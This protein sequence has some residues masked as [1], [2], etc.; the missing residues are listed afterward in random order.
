[1][2]EKKTDKK[3]I[4]SQ[5]AK[6]LLVFGIL[7]IITSFIMT[8]SEG[9]S[10]KYKLDPE[11]GIIGPITTSKKNT[12]Y[13]I[14]VEQNLAQDSQWSFVSGEL[15]DENKNYLFGFGEEFWKESGYDSEGYWS[16]KVTN[17]DMDITIP[18]KG[19]YYLK[20]NSEIAQGV[21]VPILINLK[22]K[23][24]TGSAFVLM[25]IITL[26]IGVVINQIAKNT[27]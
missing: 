9:K 10:Q 20:F 24:G 27:K 1:M 5:S 7:C 13:E 11:G 2:N 12:V 17:Y 6:I 26:V 14:Y 16:D 23:R 22:K 19:S 18:E 21:N 8:G 3:K 15:L 4:L 25:G